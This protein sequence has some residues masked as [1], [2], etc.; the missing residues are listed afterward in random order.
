[1]EA[2]VQLLDQLRQILVAQCSP[3]KTRDEAAA[4][5]KIS[6]EQFDK[7]V[8]KGRVARRYCV[9]SPRFRVEELDEL[10]TEEKE[11]L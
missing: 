3:W 2:P 5:L 6:V 10:I 1:M 11:R 4:Y 7:L 9:A 8:A